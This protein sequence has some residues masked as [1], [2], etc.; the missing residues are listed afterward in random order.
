MRRFIITLLSGV[1]FA[2][3]MAVPAAADNDEPT[4]AEIVIDVS[5]TDGLDNNS[6]DFDILLAAVLADPVL[7]DALLDAKASWTV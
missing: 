6:K 7:A 4:I 5:S 1:L 3:L 2:G